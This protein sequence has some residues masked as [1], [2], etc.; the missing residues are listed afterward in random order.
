LL[1]AIDALVAREFT[2]ASVA[3]GEMR[4]PGVPF[5]A[6]VGDAKVLASELK[7]TVSEIAKT[8]DGKDPQMKV[9]ERILGLLG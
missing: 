8:I 2:P 7:E 6:M 5:S 9:I 3:K 4:H 1:S